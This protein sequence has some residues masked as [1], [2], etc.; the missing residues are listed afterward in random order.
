MSDLNPYDQIIET[1]Q[2]AKPD[3]RVTTAL[4]LP[5]SATVDDVVGAIKARGCPR[6]DDT[7]LAAV[8]GDPNQCVTPRKDHPH[9]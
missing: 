8:M 9:A 2:T 4:G 1:L 6:C 7:K 3:P 5:E